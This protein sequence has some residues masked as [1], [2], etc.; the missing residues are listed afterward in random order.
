MCLAKFDIV[1]P[2]HRR[3]SQ[4]SLTS[5]LRI[6]CPVKIDIVVPGP[7]RHSQQSRISYLRG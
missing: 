1:D 7:V 3:H 4:Q 2:Y 6:V 5:Y